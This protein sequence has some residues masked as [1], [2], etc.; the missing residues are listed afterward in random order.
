MINFIIQRTYSPA[1][2]ERHVLSAT[3]ADAKAIEW[4]YYNERPDYPPPT[5]HLIGW[6][7]AGDLGPIAWKFEDSQITL[8]IDP[9]DLYPPA[10]FQVH[11]RV[12]PR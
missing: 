8:A 4:G 10:P 6:A 1:K 9:H 12:H 11:R 3:E 7:N 5:E 2:H